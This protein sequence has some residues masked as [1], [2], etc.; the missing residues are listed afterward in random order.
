MSHRRVMADV[1]LTG[2]YAKISFEATLP[3][4]E[5]LGPNPEVFAAT[6]RPL[7]LRQIETLLEEWL[8][9]FLRPSDELLTSLDTT[10]G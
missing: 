4:P 10:C 6:W 3:L 2:G 5:S 8:S 1:V 7:P 9:G